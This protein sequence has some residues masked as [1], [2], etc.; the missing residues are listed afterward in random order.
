M[1]PILKALSLIGKVFSQPIVILFKIGIKKVGGK[2]R[3]T[4]VKWGNVVTNWEAWV[5]RRFLGYEG[6]MKEIMLT[7][8]KALES[9]ANFFIEIVVIYGVLG[10]YTISSGIQKAHDS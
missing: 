1:I 3:E 10:Y 5:N 8:D 2:P 9:F 7:E 4:L 6:E